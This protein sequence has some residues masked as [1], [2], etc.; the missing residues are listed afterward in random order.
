MAKEEKRQMKRITI[1]ALVLV[2]CLGAIGVGYAN[3]T[4]EIDINGDVETGT[5]DLSVK[6]YMG[7]YCYKNLTTHGM[8]WYP[9]LQSDPN[10]YYVAGAWGRVGDEDDTIVLEWENI[11]PTC[12]KSFTAGAIFEYFGIPA[13]VYWTCDEL[14]ADSQWIEPYLDVQW[15]YNDGTEWKDLVFAGGAEIPTE[16]YNGYTLR[17]KVLVQLPQDNSLMDMDASFT[18]R[19]EVEQWACK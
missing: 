12:Q 6:G 5:V 10:L 9:T 1:L 3:W 13:V 2:L 17:L 16:L 18:C 4:D 8:E 14:D 15:S 11:F 7:G 19:V